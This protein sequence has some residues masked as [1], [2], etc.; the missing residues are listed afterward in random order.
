MRPASTNAGATA[1][2]GCTS[3]GASDA[4]LARVETGARAFT[5]VAR[6]GAPGVRVEVDVVLGPLLRERADDALEPAGH[7]WPP[8][9][10]ERYVAYRSVHH[11]RY[12]TFRLF[13]SCL[14]GGDM[15]EEET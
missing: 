9:R 3:R 10:W 1:R 11:K 8:S 6:G 7:G 13:T 14:R 5:V 2:R 15:T 4:E 12:A